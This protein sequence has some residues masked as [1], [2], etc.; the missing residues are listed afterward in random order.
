MNYQF[1][2]YLFLKPLTFFSMLPLIAFKL[3]DVS[4]GIVWLILFGIIYP[5]ALCMRLHILSE[6]HRA[7]L[8]ERISEWIVYLP[9]I[10]VQETRHCLQNM[11]F[12]TPEA[13]HQFYLRS[14]MYKLVLHAVAFYVL[15]LDI[16]YSLPFNW[17]LLAAVIVFIVLLKSTCSTL[18]SMGAVFA[19]RYEVKQC[20]D[21][22]WFEASFKGKP[23][24]SILLRVT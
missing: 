4:A 16:N 22:P 14:L 18:A 20:A 9:G 24:L 11:A 10:P 1:C 23:G 8:K 21:N 15:Y 3:L 2:W 12:E 19:R 7:R 6:K 17:T 5:V 13:L